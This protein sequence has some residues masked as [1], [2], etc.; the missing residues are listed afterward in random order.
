MKLKFE[1]GVQHRCTS[2]VL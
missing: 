1:V 2:F